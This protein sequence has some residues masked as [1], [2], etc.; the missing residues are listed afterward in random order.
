MAWRSFGLQHTWYYMNN[1]FCFVP[2]TQSILPLLES[3]LYATMMECVNG[4]LELSLPTW[5][6]DKCAVS[7]VATSG[8]YPG[9][10]KKGCTIHGL[11]NLEVMYN[12][13]C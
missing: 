12:M 5:L 7:V 6:T 11:Q 1:K 4:E 13:L 10:Y 3:D 2:E 9:S 8:G